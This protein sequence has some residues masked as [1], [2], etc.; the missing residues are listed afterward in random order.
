MFIKILPKHPLF[1]F[2]FIFVTPFFQK[3]VVSIVQPKKSNKLEQA[4][5]V[6]IKQLNFMIVHTFRELANKIQTEW[7]GST[8]HT[9]KQDNSRIKSTYI[10][11]QTK[12]FANFSPAEKETG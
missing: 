4:V 7:T 6:T 8:G 1:T 9:E 12:L 11:A 2:R 3:L 10:Y 5:Y